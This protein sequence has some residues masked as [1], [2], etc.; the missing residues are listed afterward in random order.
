[1]RRVVFALASLAVACLFAAGCDKCGDPVKFNT[2]SL[3]K[4]CY[5][6]APQK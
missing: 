1:M 2:P 3:P 5:D 4:A 6:S